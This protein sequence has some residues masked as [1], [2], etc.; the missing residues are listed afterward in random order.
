MEEETSAS[1][2]DK[3]S[4]DTEWQS[5]EGK[6]G[7]EAIS[8]HEEIKDLLSLYWWSLLMVLMPWPEIMGPRITVMMAPDTM[9]VRTTSSQA[10]S[11][12]RMKEPEP[13]TITPN[14]KSKE[15]KHRRMRK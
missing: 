10:R 15:K 7:P 3:P 2:I 5:Q 11:S 12:W 1:K 14:M 9:Q 13:F 6:P 8:N 4:Q